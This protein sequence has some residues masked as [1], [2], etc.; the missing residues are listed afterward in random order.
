M[1]ADREPT[2][3]AF[4]RLRAATDRIPTK[5]FASIATGLF[6]AA[7]AAFGGL[8]TVT[9][10][11][12]AL[13]QWQIGDRVEGDQL[14]IT[15]ERAVLID[16]LEGSGAT[17]DEA[18]GERLL[19]LLVEAE[20]LADE[21]VGM[22]ANSSTKSNTVLLLPDE[23]PATQITREDDATWSPWLQPNVPA[24]V[25]FIWTVPGADYA[26][27]DRL[28]LTV[29]NTTLEQFSFLTSGTYWSTPEKSGTLTVELEDVG[30]GVQ[31]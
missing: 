13:P 30:A 20:N 19:V 25:V 10:P 8:N 23:R 17:P 29:Q 5:W 18:A 16:D 26:E 27:G 4:A 22:Y 31:Q 1:H 28:E 11:A 9:P 15:V 6:L 24:E 3:S 2:R 12:V 14:A 7:T 21:A